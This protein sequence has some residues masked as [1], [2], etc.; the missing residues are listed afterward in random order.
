MCL[1]RTILKAHQIFHSHEHP[2]VHTAERLRTNANSQSYDLHVNN[3]VDTIVTQSIGKS[4]RTTKSVRLNLTLP[5]CVRL[6]TT[7][8][9]TNTSAEILRQSVD[10]IVHLARLNFRAHFGALANFFLLAK[11]DKSY[12]S[13]PL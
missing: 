10:L 1:L 11:S 5:S 8:T 3:N 2:I 9:S 4:I 7:T 13:H 6:S 12:V